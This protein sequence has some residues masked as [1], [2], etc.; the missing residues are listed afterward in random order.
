MRDCPKKP[1]ASQVAP[2]GQAPQPR[3][4]GPKVAAAQPTVQKK[5]AD[6]NGTGQDF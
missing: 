4:E 6:A 2:K 3:S 5:K 1:V